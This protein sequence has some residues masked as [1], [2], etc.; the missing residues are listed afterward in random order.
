MS[1]VASLVDGRLASS[2]LKL[3]HQAAS[4]STRLGVPLY[5]VGGT[6][7]DILAG[8]QPVDLDVVAVGPTPDFAAALVK[9]LGGTLV[10]HSQFGTFKLKAGRVEIDVA[11]A[12][13]ET[14]SRPGA[15]PTVA[16][17]TIEP[18]LARRDFSI[19]AM[20][21]SLAD[22]SWG[23]LLDPFNGRTDLGD[24]V[25][26][27]LHSNSFMDDATRI[28]RAV[29]YMGRLDFRLEVETERLLRRDLRRLDDISGDRIRHELDRM[30]VEPKAPVVL[31]AAQEL[32]VLV[33]VHPALK[34]SREIPAEFS[35][36]A[37]VPVTQKNLVLLAALV[38]SAT[39]DQR[40][41]L[42]RRLN[43]DGQWARVVED[44]GALRSALKRLRA[45]GLRDSQS[46]RLL[47]RL[48]LASIE[49]CALATDEP[50]VWERLRLYLEELRHVRGELDGDDVIALGVSRGPR[51]GELLDKV[52]MARLD[53]L[54]STRQDEE[55][56][57]R[58]SLDRDTA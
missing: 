31:Q 23:E 17:G 47:R 58:R 48:R 45:P 22:E 37:A 56:L 30:L 34:I 28:L 5:L 42:T 32:R 20:A 19:N 12:R 13:S 8:R 55:N 25:I 26:R 39:D 2:H 11:S 50:L 9:G 54:L 36:G 1:N 44:V 57:V 53:G 33:A 15:L 21:V 4:F 7:R 14:Y 29:R 40:V 27:V 24:R 3:L 6:V 16:P 38:Y 49:G 18:D 46:Y 41:G 35:E 52:L 10:A 51:V 43:L